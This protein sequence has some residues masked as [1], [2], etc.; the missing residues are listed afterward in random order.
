VVRLYD[1]SNGVNR[2]CMG[3][4]WSLRSTYGQAGCDSYASFW[5]TRCGSLDD[6]SRLRVSPRKLINDDLSHSFDTQKQGWQVDDYE[7][8]VLAVVDNGLK[9]V[10]STRR[11]S[12]L[13]LITPLPWLPFSSAASVLL[14]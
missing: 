12:E 4:R 9:I 1:E 10:W 7:N 13:Q 5:V 3:R 2:R 11:L 14:L 6:D 8:V